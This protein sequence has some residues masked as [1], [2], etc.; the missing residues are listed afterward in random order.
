LLIQDDLKLSPSDALLTMRES[1][2]FGVAMFPHGGE[3]G[4][5]DGEMGVVDKMMM[6]QAERRRKE[7]EV[8]EREENEAFE[9]ELK[10]VA[11]RERNANV[12]GKEKERGNGR[13]R[14]KGMEKEKERGK[15]KNRVKRKDKGST[16]DVEVVASS[17]S[18]QPPLRP[19]PKP[20][21]QVTGQLS[22][23]SANRRT[24]P[25]PGPASS[26]ARDIYKAL[27]GCTPLHPSSSNP[28]ISHP[29]GGSQSRRVTPSEVA[30]LSV[31][32]GPSD[33]EERSSQSVTTSVRRIDLAKQ[34]GSRTKRRV[35]ADRS[36]E[37][38]VLLERSS[39]N[40]SGRRPSRGGAYHSDFVDQNVTP[41][42]VRVR[43]GAEAGEE[44]N[45]DTP[46][47]RRIRGLSTRPDRSSPKE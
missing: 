27:G 22:D 11:E 19:R 47:P 5:R 9:K 6:E 42:P 8:E 3:D 46:R 38:D 14:E 43:S 18:S 36:F 30:T 7:L 40:G 20:A 23:S 17:Q 16:T 39:A 24:P 32:S 26:M 15:E 29:A 28:D 12:K 21:L 45:G 25:P 41:T 10:E 37:Q 2:Q 44:N 33:I 35:K 4:D 31:S 1:V 34:P 13:G